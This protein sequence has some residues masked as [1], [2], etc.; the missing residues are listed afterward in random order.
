MTRM[1]KVHAV[2]VMI[3]SMAFC[4]FFQVSKHE[5][6]L[7]SLNPFGEDPYDSV[8]SFGAQF[9]LFLSVLSLLRAFRPYPGGVLKEHQAVLARG[10]MM[11]V[12]AVGITLVVDLIAMARHT[13][14]WMVSI[15]GYVLGWVTLGF[16][17]VVVV[18]GWYLYGAAQTSGLTADPHA[19]KRMAVVCSGAVVV[20]GLYPESLRHYLFGELFTVLVGTAVLFIPIRIVSMNVVQETLGAHSDSLDDVASVYSG[21]RGAS[22]S[23]SLMY[24]VLEAVLDSRFIRA[25]AGVLNPRRHRWNLMVATAML[26]GAALIIAELREPGSAIPTS[27]VFLLIAVYVGLETAG[28]ALGYS[29]LSKP[30]RLFRPLR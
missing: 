13:T 17:V 8:G 3:L 14:M 15:A 2:I 12:L 28:V 30:L 20:V 29:L 27:R 18:E 16:F 21:L 5:P 9:V 10:E 22:S 24:D 7:R 1:L 11:V 25:V 19:W 4:V 23:F 6:A 26:I